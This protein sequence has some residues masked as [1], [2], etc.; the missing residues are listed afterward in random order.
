MR[1]WFWVAAICLPAQAHAQTPMTPMT[2]EKPDVHIGDT[3]SY[4]QTDGFTDEVTAEFSRRVTG[5]SDTEITSQQEMK[6]GKNKRMIWFDRNWNLIDNGNGQYAPSLDLID[7]PLHAGDTWKHQYKG[8]ILKTGARFV[9]YVTGKFIGSE[10]V[11]VPAGTFEAG[12]IE[13]NVECRAED[14][15]A[16]VTR[17]RNIDWWT[18]GVNRPVRAEE[19]VIA[20]GRVRRKSVVELVD[21]ARAKL[22]EH[23]TGPSAPSDAQPSAPPESSDSAQSPAK[24]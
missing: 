13:T 1:R 6:D 21:Y 12:R 8:V 9:C 20:N 4:R 18:P 10:S 17:F 23:D 2:L 3:W 11:T 22:D 16:T 19:S 7:F 15:N 14:A 5:L 24:P